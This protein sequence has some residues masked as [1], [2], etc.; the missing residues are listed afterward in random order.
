MS[1]LFLFMSSPNYRSLVLMLLVLFLL[2]LISASEFYLEEDFSLVC[3]NST[4]TITIYNQSQYFSL[5][6]DERFCF[7]EEEPEVDGNCVRQQI[8][9]TFVD[10]HD[11][12]FDSHPILETRETNDRGE[13]S[14]YFPDETPTLVVIRSSG[15]EDIE[16]VV[17][18]RICYRESSP[19]GIEEPE[20]LNSLSFAK[21]EVNVTITN[22][23]LSLE[24]FSLSFLNVS[25]S[26]LNLTEDRIVSKFSM[27]VLSEINSSVIVGTLSL[28]IPIPFYNSSHN[29]TLNLLSNSSLE[30]L[31][32]ND[33]K[34]RFE[35]FN[36]SMGTYYIVEDVFEVEVKNEDFEISNQS[37]VG[38]GHDTETLAGENIWGLKSNN[39]RLLV[40]VVVI[41]IAI[42]ILFLASFKI[43]HLQHKESNTIH[44]NSE[45]FRK[46]VSYIKANRKKYS[47]SSIFS[48]LEKSG[49]PKEV[50]QE[51]F[52]SAT[53]FRK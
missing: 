14:V 41:I 32:L 35:I 40:Q 23:S 1:C 21:D 48:V 12:P 2:S 45:S 50:I 26:D 8:F 25:S 6:D 10:V 20:I 16:E 17:V 9:S 51:A 43:L 4:V 31:L 42:V 7:D 29:Y 3:A 27:E 49:I 5:E 38:K 52:R 46:I 30:E 53:D 11:G 15:F 36:A 24:D 28:V 47:D 33:N 22:T 44:T 13:V 18:P 34:S 19:S 39:F 37:V